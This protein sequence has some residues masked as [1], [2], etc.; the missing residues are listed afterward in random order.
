VNMAWRR[1]QNKNIR[2]KS[3]YFGAADLS[4]R[5]GGCAKARDVGQ[6]RLLTGGITKMDGI[7]TNFRTIIN[8]NYRSHV[9]FLKAGGL[10][11]GG[12]NFD[13]KKS[14]ETY[15]FWTTFS[16]HILEGRYLC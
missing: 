8:K 12:V 10:Q 3:R 5:I 14:E 9:V 13:A 15:G 2:G 11:G 4:T 6:Y 7:P 16:M 1:I